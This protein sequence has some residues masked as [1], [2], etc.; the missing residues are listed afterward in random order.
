LTGFAAN[1]CVLFTANDAHM[2]GYH[3]VVPSDC[4][5]SNTPA[6]T[7]SALAHVEVALHG[8]VKRSTTLD[9]VSLGRR[10]RKPRDQTF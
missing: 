4:T 9:F 5:A 8:D 6:L 2:R 3:V 7:R 10:P 1:L